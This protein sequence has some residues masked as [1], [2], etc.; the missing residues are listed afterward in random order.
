MLVLKDFSIKS[1]VC[2]VEPAITLDKR[3]LGD[4]TLNLTK[5]IKPT[6]PAYGVDLSPI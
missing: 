3:R 1:K 6:P 2:P 4:A 5:R